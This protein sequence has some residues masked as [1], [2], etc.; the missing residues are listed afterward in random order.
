MRWYAPIVYAWAAPA[1][2]IGLALAPI[3]L[4]QGGT[5]RWARGV[6]EIQGGAVTA[7]LRRGLP[8][9]A[10]AAAMTIG[11]VVWGRDQRCL[12]TSRAHELVHVRQYERW[13]PFFIPAYL[14]ASLIARLRGLDAYLD[15]P[16]EREAYD[17]AP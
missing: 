17:K 8:W 2:A 1:T 3:V 16:F 11:H 5:A 15:N 13:G 6:I 7:L 9:G 12:D 10:P 4:W 14:L